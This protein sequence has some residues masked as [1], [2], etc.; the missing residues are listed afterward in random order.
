MSGRLAEAG[1]GGRTNPTAPRDN[2]Y[3]KISAAQSGRARASRT[4]ATD[5]VHLAGR[6]SDP[7]PDAPHCAAGPSPR[8]ARR[9]AGSPA[10][11]GCRLPP[12]HSFLFGGG[13]GGETDPAPPGLGGEGRAAQHAALCSPCF[14]EHRP[15]PGSSAEYG[16]RRGFLRALPDAA[17]A[18][19]L[20]RH[21]C[22]SSGACVVG[23]AYDLPG[24]GLNAGGKP[25]SAFY[26]GRVLYHGLAQHR[27]RPG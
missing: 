18:L 25:E 19:S 23:L 24:E 7:E 14:K 27:Q 6:T 26:D 11:G 16:V 21:G 17:S 1:A 15:P 4:T 3:A 22:V 13:G 2:V 10:G 20:R 12:S 9:Q 5:P 8:G